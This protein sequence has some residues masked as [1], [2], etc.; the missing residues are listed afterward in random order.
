MPEQLLCVVPA[1]TPPQICQPT[2]EEWVAI[3]RASR[4]T[5]WCPA[6]ANRSSRCVFTVIS[7]YGE[8]WSVSGPEAGLV[9]SEL[10]SQM[11]R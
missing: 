4:H 8:I 10:K 2:Y 1:E 11:S 9:T 7:P 5:S 3:V 6:Q